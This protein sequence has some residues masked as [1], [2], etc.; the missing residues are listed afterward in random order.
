MT[1][2]CH[3]LFGHECELVEI[4]QR[5]DGVTFCRVK[6]GEFGRSDVPINATD[7]GIP[8][9]LPDSLLSYRSVQQLL[10][11]Y[12]TIREAR[13]DKAART[14][15]DPE[16]QRDGTPASVAVFDGQGTSAICTDRG[17][18]LPTAGQSPD[19]TRGGA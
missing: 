19:E 15:Q 7:R 16:G 10:T 5:Q 12:Q 8:L 1:D 18:D 13:D 9:P 17:G 2:P 11:T 4:Y 14:K 3:P 6:V